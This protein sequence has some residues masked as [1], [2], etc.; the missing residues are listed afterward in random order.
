M[1]ISADKNN[2]VS[3]AIFIEFLYLFKASQFSLIYT[4]NT[5]LLFFSV[6]VLISS[7]LVNS[8]NLFIETLNFLIKFLKIED[9]YYQLNYSFGNVILFSYFLIT[10]IIY[11]ANRWWHKIF[12]KT[13]AIK[14]KYKI[15]LIPALVSLSY[16]LI[17]YYFSSNT[18]SSTKTDNTIFIVLAIITILANYYYL[19][20]GIS[21]NYLKNRFH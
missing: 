19:G 4:L 11:I 12:D 10:F 15:I 18:N 2:D 14:T 8:G 13:F 17:I 9:G 16:G 3:K 6:S 7:I 21:I 5:I 20:V 1:S